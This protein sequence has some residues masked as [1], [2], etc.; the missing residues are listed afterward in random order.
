MSDVEDVNSWF[1]SP[2]TF[3]AG[4]GLML[5]FKFFWN[6]IGVL[7]FLPALAWLFSRP[8]AGVK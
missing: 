6:M 4:M 1:L 2:I 5:T 8:L 3:Q 7:L